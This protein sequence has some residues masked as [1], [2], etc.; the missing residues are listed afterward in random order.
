MK[1]GYSQNRSIVKLLSRRWHSWLISVIRNC[2]SCPSEPQH[3]AVIMDL[4]SHGS[5]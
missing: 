5:C 3:L 4:M 2:W 1:L